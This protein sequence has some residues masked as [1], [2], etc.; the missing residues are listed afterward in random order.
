MTITLTNLPADVEQALLARAT[1]EQRPVESVV[2]D[3]VVRELGVE[4]PSSGN[5]IRQADATE[6]S[7]SGGFTESAP[8]DTSR[9]TYRTNEYGAIL[10]RPATTDAAGNPLPKKRDLSDLAG[11][12]H[13]DED[14]LKALEDQR[15]IDWELWQ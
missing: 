7:T 13:L 5:G 6:E 14:V 4:Q 12:Q 10:V 8:V 15:R 1:A 9:T 11:K 2:L 3:A